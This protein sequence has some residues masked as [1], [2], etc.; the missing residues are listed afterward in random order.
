MTDQA[1]E[2]VAF[3][4]RGLLLAIAHSACAMR[5]EAHALE[6]DPQFGADNAVGRRLRPTAEQYRQDADL[7]V[8]WVK[9]HCASVG[10]SEEDLPNV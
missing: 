5:R 4:T 6:S 8:G 10:L 7:I 2:P 3:L 1:V 9:R